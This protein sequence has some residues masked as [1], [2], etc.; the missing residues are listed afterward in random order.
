VLLVDP[1]LVSDQVEAR[2][3]LGHLVADPLLVLAQQREALAFVAGTIADQFGEVP[4]RGEGHPGRAGWV[5]DNGNQV[6][7]GFKTPAQG[8]A[9]QVWAATSPRLAGMGG[10]YCEDC[11]I[12]DPEGRTDMVAG[13][14][15]RTGTE[16]AAR[17][18]A[19]SAELTGVDAFATWVP[20]SP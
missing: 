14:H 20:A 15:W 2:G 10:V 11:D 6:G 17:L 3:E 1:D 4:D 5:D 12:A 9:T 16:Q 8:A 18:W 19:L 7:A 13:V